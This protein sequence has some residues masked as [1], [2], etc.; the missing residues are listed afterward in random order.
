M[1]KGKNTLVL[2]M[3]LCLLNSLNVTGQI[4]GVNYQALIEAPEQVYKIPGTDFGSNYF[5]SSALKMRFTISNEMGDEYTEVH[6][7]TTNI[8]GEVN[9][10]I[11]NGKSFSGP[12][13]EV[14]WDGKPKQLKVEI[15]YLMGAG[16]EYIGTEN[17]LYLPHPL[18]KQDSERIDN[19]KA[20]VENI[21]QASGFTPQGAYKTNSDAR[22]I[23]N[24]R[25][26]ASADD[27]LAQQVQLNS[28][29]IDGMN[30][31][32]KIEILTLEDD[33]LTV[34]VERGG[35]K[36]VDLSPIKDGTGTDDQNA[37]EVMLDEQLL[38]LDDE[39][40]STE[41]AIVA[42]KKYMDS[43]ASISSDD[44]SFTLN[45]ETHV[46]ALE[47]GGEVDMS[48]YVNT[49]DQTAEEIEFVKQM[50]INADGDYEDN[51][52]QALIKLVDML[53]G[54]TQPDACNYDSGSLF[55]NDDLCEYQN[56]IPESI[57]PGISFQGG[58]VVAYNQDTKEGL[59]VASSDVSVGPWNAFQWGCA[60]VNVL[61]TSEA[62]GAGT[63]NTNA[64]LRTC[65]ERST[66][67]SMCESYVLNGFTDWVLPSVEDLKKIHEN[68]EFLAVD[69]G[70]ESL[71]PNVHYWSSSQATGYK[72]KGMYSD[73]GTLIELEKDSEHK[74][75]PV[76]YFKL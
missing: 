44:Q 54:C 22:Y 59:I 70:Y 19:N 56:C 68:E 57:E 33:S 49:D 36:S 65:S 5:R 67:A 26:L 75:R 24:A 23:Q 58:F 42:L 38:I 48:A 30:D 60:G 55:G 72:A 15:D 63:E 74:L 3:L 4:L 62:M 6:S 16:F 51:V 41:E 34:G 2:L 35:S 14:V 47:D 17:L 76:R 12:F 50:D 27:F 11:G 53:Y 25:S 8:F 20:L 61:S 13:S 66:A 9:L 73:D 40:N 7:D 29:R 10:I 18:S 39:T 37:S 21:I 28:E 46:L 64:I 1:N 31:N 32:Q 43:L 45:E 71:T 69:Q 52:E